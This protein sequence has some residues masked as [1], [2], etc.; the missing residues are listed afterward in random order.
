MDCSY[1][2]LSNLNIIKQIIYIF[3]HVE[4]KLLFFLMD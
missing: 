1:L 2:N 4:D 3:K